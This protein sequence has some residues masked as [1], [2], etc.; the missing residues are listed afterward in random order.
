LVQ[1][2]DYTGTKVTQSIDS[3]SDTSIQVD[4][5]SGAL[6]DTYCFLFVTND[7]AERGFIAVQ[8]GLPPETYAEAVLGM[9][10]APDHYWQFQNS[11]A[12]SVGT[13]TADNSSGGTPTF[14]SSVKLV[15]GDTHSL[16]LDSETDFISPADQTDMNSSALTRRYIGG[17]LQLDSV[18]QT[19]SVLYEEGC[20]G[21]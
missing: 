19:L 18:S 7:S 9:A 8:V 5:S 12:D 13:A 3:W 2:S 14:S 10:S 20:A 4:I 11:Y 17:W 6:A 15:K 21:Q 16:Q 1:N